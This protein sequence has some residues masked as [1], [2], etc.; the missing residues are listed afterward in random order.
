MAAPTSWGLQRDAA[1]KWRLRPLLQKL[2][3]TMVIGEPENGRVILFADFEPWLR[4][5][6]PKAIHS[7]RKRGIPGSI[8]L[9]SLESPEISTR[10]TEKFRCLFDPEVANGMK[11]QESF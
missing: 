7:D 5:K 11:V 8:R 6:M 2:L 3:F 1:M 10:R 4:L 9:D